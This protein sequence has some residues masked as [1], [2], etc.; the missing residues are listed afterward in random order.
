MMQQQ[1][2]EQE[3]ICRSDKNIAH[4]YLQH[5]HGHP[6]LDDITLT[7]SI[8]VKSDAEAAVNEHAEKLASLIRCLTGIYQVEKNQ[9]RLRQAK[10]AAVHLIE[11][12]NSNLPYL[13]KGRNIIPAL[14]EMYRLTEEDYY[15]LKAQ[16][17]ADRLY[18]SSNA[19]TAHIDVQANMLSLL[20][21]LYT[22]WPDKKLMGRINVIAGKLIS[23][24]AI[25]DEG[26]YWRP[27][28]VQ[29]PIETLHLQY[30]LY[31]TWQQLGDFTGNDTFYE[32]SRRSRKYISSLEE[33]ISNG[34][35]VTVEVPKLPINASLL[36]LATGS[37]IDSP[38]SDTQLSPVLAQYR[39]QLLQGLCTSLPRDI[40]NDIVITA[41]LLSGC[42]GQISRAEH[43]DGCNLQMTVR[44]LNRRLLHNTFENTIG[45]LQFSLGRSGK[46]CR[47]LTYNDLQTQDALHCLLSE[48]SSYLGVSRRSDI[49]QHH[50]YELELHNR[51][52]IIAREAYPYHAIEKVV[53]PQDILSLTLRLH[54]NMMRME[55]PADISN[56]VRSVIFRDAQMPPG[57]Y[58]VAIFHDISRHL[59]KSMILQ[60]NQKMVLEA[61][62][63]LADGHPRVTDL[64]EYLATNNDELTKIEVSEIISNFYDAGLLIT[65]N[66][67]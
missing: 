4:H 40:V 41:N 16:V 65:S 19:P 60:S 17:V 45:M 57:D 22:T 21:E 9:D 13:Y 55:L 7:M 12:C 1:V 2:Y 56:K 54:P 61:F 24:A 26:I 5:V 14:L 33:N 42:K 18:E 62:G 38:S 27:A 28:A 44:E 67:R 46:I 25:C 31:A 52:M 34:Q 50:A 39:D 43:I 59:V 30:L 29:S 49:M 36:A 58:A 11:C 64:L 53:Q 63:Q 15:L 35:P 48:Y 8:L 51:S 37:G 3:A 47:E 10:I 23:N 66:Q 20:Q 32:L 6:A